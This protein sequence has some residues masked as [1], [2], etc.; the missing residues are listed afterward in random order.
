VISRWVLRSETEV[1]LPS[2]GTFR[3][4]VQNLVLVRGPIA[5]VRP[6]ILALRLE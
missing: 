4:L 3:T 6:P 2:L 5:A 1:W